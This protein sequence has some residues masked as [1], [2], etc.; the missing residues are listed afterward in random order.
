MPITVSWDNAS[1]II[2]RIHRTSPWDWSDYDRSVDESYALVRSVDHT[3]Y[4]IL[5]LA[6]GDKFPAG[7]SV[8]HIDRMLEMRP[9]NAGPTVV[10]GAK[11]A[12]TF[13]NVIF[14]AVNKTKRAADVLQY[15]ESLEDAYALI[16]EF[17]KAPADEDEM[18]SSDN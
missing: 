14:S 17:Q 13:G 9:K 10:V 2:V 8:P 11:K 5:M 3:V 15:V 6:P 18:T 4:T 7:R 16:A 12:D 1:R